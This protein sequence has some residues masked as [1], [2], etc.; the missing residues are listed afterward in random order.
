MHLSNLQTKLVNKPIPE[1]I[2]I[3]IIFDQ[4]GLT[5]ESNKT[6]NTVWKAIKKW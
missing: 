6:R 2:D 5:G 4:I 3:D 1:M